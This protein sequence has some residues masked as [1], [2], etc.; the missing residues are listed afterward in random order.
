MEEHY[1]LGGYE[2]V[3]RGYNALIFSGP[4]QADGLYERGL[5]LR[6]DFESVVA[7][8]LDLVLE[9]SEVDDGRIAIIGRSFG[10]YLAPRAS[11]FEQRLSA[12]IADPGQIDLGKNL[13]DRLPLEWRE[14]LDANDPAFNDAFWESN[15]GERGAE[16]WGSRM[17]AHGVKTPLELAREM[18]RW[19]VPAERIE[20]P[21]FVSQAEGDYAGQ[22][23]EH[24]A[25][26]I[27]GP[28]RFVQFTAAEGSGGHCEGM[29]ASRF[30]ERA[31]GWLDV[32]FKHSS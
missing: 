12:L 7:P 6:H 29:G 23:G 27:S 24:L 10:G 11:A 17:A 8:A 19:V 31:F 2:A 20:C 5:P 21:A 28:V 30:Y 15:P 16:F 32:T 26:G 25:K 22:Y 18:T 9:R 3:A 14:M 13:R 4:G 1:S